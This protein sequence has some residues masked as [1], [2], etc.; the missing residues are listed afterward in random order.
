MRATV[1]HAPHDIRVQEVPDPSVQQPT[2]VV[3][4]VLRACICGSDLWAYRGEAA[5]QPGQRIGHEFLGIVE[6]AGSEVA[7]FAVGDLVVAP[8]V[9]SDG[10]CAYCAEGL[11]TSCPQGGFWGSV[12]SDGGQGEAV[13]VPFADGTLV[14]LP[15]AA[16]SDDRL[17]TALLALSDVLGTGHHAAVGAGVKTGSTVAVVGDGAVGLCGVLAAKR[18]G[19]ER[20]IALG[21]HRARTDIARAFGATDVVAERG[22]A[23]VEAV[24][25]LLGGEGAHAVIEAVGTEQSMR[26]AV[27]ITRDGGAIGYVGVPHGSGTGLDLGVMF[28]RNIALR[29]GV[30]PVRAYIPELLPDVLSGTIDPSPVFDLT[31]G[32]DDVPAGYK[33]MDERTALKVLIKP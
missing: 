7:G 20:I 33:A 11:T 30:A 2:D 13:R 12:G 10:T 21:R 23:A 5:R 1:I 26:T 32:L 3:L 29:G 25:E 14:K 17:L 18:L 19:A 22:E 6:E 8:F 31:I 15:A 9:W 28:D 24:R 16:A 4:R 27:G